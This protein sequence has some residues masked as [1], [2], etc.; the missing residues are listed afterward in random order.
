MGFLIGVFSLPILVSDTLSRGKYYQLKFKLSTDT[1][2]A[3]YVGLYTQK[4]L[5]ADMLIYD[6][7]NK[8]LIKVVGTSGKYPTQFNFPGNGIYYAKIVAYSGEGPFLMLISDKEELKKILKD[9]K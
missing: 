5:D 9:V 4:A 2:K 1:Q 7:D 3:R 8:L 6:E